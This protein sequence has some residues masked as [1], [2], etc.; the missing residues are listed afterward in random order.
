MINGAMRIGSSLA[1]ALGQSPA[2]AAARAPERLYKMRLN[3]GRTHLQGLKV[4]GPGDVIEVSELVARQL[5]ADRVAVAV[6]PTEFS[7]L[8]SLPPDPEVKR[9]NY[10]PNVPWVKVVVDPK[11]KNNTWFSAWEGRTYAAGE[12]LE[13]P[14]HQAVEGFHFGVLKL[15]DGEGGLTTRGKQYLENLKKGRAAD[16]SKNYLYGQQ[17]S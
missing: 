10:G 17:A 2:A 8:L 16:S 13:V 11:K 12:K 4:F 5:F 15:A 6:N 1:L 14:E 7:P 9:P 3:E